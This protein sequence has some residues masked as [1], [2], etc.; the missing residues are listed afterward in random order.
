MNITCHIDDL[1]L[2]HKKIYDIKNLLMW[3]SDIDV[4][5]NV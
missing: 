3:M 4:N 2:S 5:L 1:K